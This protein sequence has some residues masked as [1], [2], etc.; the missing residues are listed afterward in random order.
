MEGVVGRVHEPYEE[1]LWTYCSLV[2]PAKGGGGRLQEK[3]AAKK[4]L[5]R[6]KREGRHVGLSQGV[7]ASPTRKGKERLE[8]ITGKSTVQKVAKWGKKRR[9]RHPYRRELGWVQAFPKGGGGK[10]NGC[11]EGGGIGS[12]YGRRAG[13]RLA[14]P[15]LLKVVGGG[16]TI[17]IKGS[18]G[19]NDGR[20]LHPR[21]T[22]DLHQVA[23]PGSIRER[24]SLYGRG[25]C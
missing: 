1:G 10:K 16:V 12:F 6:L 9:V 25:H 14:S 3:G 21:E 17:P 15:F 13:E 19:G 22:D 20:F 2:L 11:H 5:N 18:R 7:D 23:V 24:E 8:E 4:A